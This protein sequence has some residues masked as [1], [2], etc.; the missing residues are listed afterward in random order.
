LRKRKVRVWKDPLGLYWW[1]CHV[2][3][4]GADIKEGTSIHWEIAQHYADEHVRE[5]HR[6]PKHVPHDLPTPPG[7]QHYDWSDTGFHLRVRDA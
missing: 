7:G 3:G 6:P 1:R 5:F 2:E 4:C